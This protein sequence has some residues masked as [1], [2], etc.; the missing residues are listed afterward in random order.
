MTAEQHSGSAVRVDQEIE[1]QPL[2]REHP[3]ILIPGKTPRLLDEWQ[4]LPALWNLVRRE[5][6]ARQG[7]GQF[8]LTGSAIPQDDSTRHS[9]AGRFKRIRMRP[10][11]LFESGISNGAVRISDLL[12]GV[13][14]KGGG[15]FEAK[16]SLKFEDV[17]SL[18]MSGGWPLVHNSS[19]SHAATWV[20]DYLEEITRV[21]LATF[22]T[23]G[24]SRDPGKIARVLRSLAR[25]VGTPVGI[26]TISQDTAGEDGGVSRETV[27]AYV[28]SL[29]RI[30]ILEHIPAWRPHLRTSK[31]LRTRSK[32]YFVDPSL[33]PAA[34]KANASILN[35]N[36]SYVGQVFENLVIR[37]LLVYAQ[38]NNAGISYYRDGTG[39]EVDAIVE[40]E[41]NSWIAVEIKLGQTYLDD[42]ASNLLKFQSLIDTKRMKEARSLIIITSGGYSYTRPDGVSVVP[43][44]LLGP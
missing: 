24:R 39:L 4:V 3:S 22:E 33:G 31:E 6:D 17:L 5:I 15:I 37:D 43:I 21:D 19:G 30:M 13:G 41:N 12:Q 23:T 40:G 8:I 34:L 18:V 32:T 35:S 14:V 42:A 38:A 16:S 25:N 10:L 29:L 9:G 28:D 36:L 44:D 7:V 11:T 27:D 20:R 1:Q 26:S 2:L